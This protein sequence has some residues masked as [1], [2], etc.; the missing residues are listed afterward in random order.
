MVDYAIFN[1][2]RDSAMELI[3]RTARFPSKLGSFPVIL[4]TKL[5]S[6]DQRSGDTRLRVRS[7]AQSRV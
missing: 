5:A 4:Q 6:L 3:R 7:R 1:L 2:D